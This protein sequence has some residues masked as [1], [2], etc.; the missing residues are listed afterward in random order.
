MKNKLYTYNISE[1]DDLSLYEF[2]YEKMNDARRKKID[3]YKFANDKKLSLAAGILLHKALSELGITEYE[4]GVVGRE[5]PVLKGHEDIFFNL[6]HSGQMAALGISDREIGIDIEKCRHFEDSLI[7]YVFTEKERELATKL[8]DFEGTPDAEKNYRREE[9]E[10][11]KQTMHPDRIVT[12]VDA[13]GSRKNVSFTK[14]DVVYTR[15]W[16]AKES[17]MKHSGLGIAMEPKKIELWP[18]EP[19]PESTII[20]AALKGPDPEKEI[21]PRLIPVCDDYDCGRLALTSYRIEGYQF[22][23]CSEYRG[24]EFDLCGN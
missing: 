10:S 18:E 7:R 11:L 19:V 23:L 22:T 3:A 12:G 21:F 5:K 14:Q 8:A 1:L 15:F 17:I 13:G 9:Q 24:S 2:W 16:T 4:I 6:S 20:G